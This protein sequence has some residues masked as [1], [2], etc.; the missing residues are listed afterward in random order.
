MLLLEFFDLFGYVPLFT[1]W[2]SERVFLG[3]LEPGTQL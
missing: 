1:F 2:V 3:G